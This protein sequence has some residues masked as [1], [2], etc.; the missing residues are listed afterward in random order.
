MISI[1]PAF[2]AGRIFCR[3]SLSKLVC[4][5]MPAA[6]SL[7]SPRLH[8]SCIQSTWPTRPGRTH[9]KEQTFAHCH[10]QQLAIRSASLRAERQHWSQLVPWTSRFGADLSVAKIFSIT[11]IFKAEFR[12]DAYNVFNHHVLGFSSAQGTVSVDNGVGS[13][14]TAIES[15]CIA[16]CSQWFAPTSVR[17]ALYVLKQSNHSTADGAPEG[18]SGPPERMPSRRPAATTHICKSLP[19][20]NGPKVASWEAEDVHSLIV[21]WR[22]PTVGQ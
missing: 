3:V 18:H 14:I 22:Q 5:V 15:E 8:R 12:F 1:R 13:R 17:C 19:Q 6:T 4:I 10:V 2:S 9:S 20:R 7:G 11:E 21:D 16:Q